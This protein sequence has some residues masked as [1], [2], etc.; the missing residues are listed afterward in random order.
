MKKIALTCLMSA[1]AFAS[2][3]AACES[4]PHIVVEKTSNHEICPNYRWLK[5][6]EDNYSYDKHIGGIEYNYAKPIGLNFNSFAG[7]SFYKGKTYVM[8]DWGIKYI[9]A[10]KDSNLALYPATGMTSTSHYSTNTDDETYQIYRSAFTGGMGASYILNDLVVFD[11]TVSYFKDLTTSC[12]LHK[13]DEFW[14]KNYHSPSGFKV[15]LAAKFLP[16]WGKPIEIGGFYA[17][18]FRNIYKEYGIKSSVTFAF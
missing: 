4:C 7:Y 16:S 1:A 17:Q 13:G 11:T 6:T 2:E 3:E 18:T 8:V 10:L 14:G 9:I 5:H 15:N 12:I